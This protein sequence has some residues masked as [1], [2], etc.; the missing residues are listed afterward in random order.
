MPELPEVETVRR[1]LEP[2]M[3]GAVLN[4]VRLY[5][6][7]LRFD[8]PQDMVTLLPTRRIEALRRRG[9]YILIDFDNGWTVIVHLGMSGSFRVGAAGALKADH[10]H[11]HVQWFYTA[12]DGENFTAIYNDPRRFGFFDM[13]RSDAAADYSAFAAMGPEPFDPAFNGAYLKAR[14]AASRAPIKQALLDQSVVAGLGNIYVCEA[15]YRAGIDPR[16]KAGAI[17]VARY[18][19]LAVH[20]VAVLNEALDSGGSTLRDHRAVDGGTGYF[21]HRFDVYDREG[22]FCANPDCQSGEKG[23]IKRIVQAGRSTFFCPVRQ[24]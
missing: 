12:A 6:P 16:R 21:Q 1:G 11:D 14:L 3:R 24:T 9:K 8:L 2:S 10:A 23:C 22:L 15:L 13:V 18:E 7:N 17:A 5:R 19:A 20:A 4:E